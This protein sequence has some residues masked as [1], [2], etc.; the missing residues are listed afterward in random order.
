MAENLTQCT[1]N[2][3]LMILG[4]KNNRMINYSVRQIM[5]EGKR[6]H[7]ARLRVF[8]SAGEDSTI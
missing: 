2:D 4:S 7:C 1:K 6:D 3:I 5:D 8:L